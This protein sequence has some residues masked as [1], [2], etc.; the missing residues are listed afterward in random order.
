MIPYF[1]GNCFNIVG[2]SYGGVIAIDIV[3]RLE[4]MGYIGKLILIDSTPK[5]MTTYIK[6]SFSHEIDETLE[7]QAIMTVLDK[8]VTVAR[9]AEVLCSIQLTYSLK[10]YSSMYIFNIQL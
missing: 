6:N 3:R 8:A 2:Y 9:K 10:S 5:M 1:E 7:V 4:K